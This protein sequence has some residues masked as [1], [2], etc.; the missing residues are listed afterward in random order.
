LQGYFAADAWPLRGFRP[1]QN[2]DG[3]NDLIVRGA[4]TLEPRLADVP[5]RMPLPEAPFQGSI[6]ENQHVLEHRYFETV[7]ETKTVAAE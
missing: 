1:G 6:Y 3:F 4:P 5:V 7:G 2:L